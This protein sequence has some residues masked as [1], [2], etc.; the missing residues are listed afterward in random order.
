MDALADHWDDHRGT[1]PTM[2]DA[3][4]VVTMAPKLGALGAAGSGA[5]VAPRPPRPAAAPARAAAGAGASQY[6]APFAALRGGLKLVSVKGQLKLDL[7][8]DAFLDIVKK[9]LEAAEVDEAF[10][11]ETYPD[12]AEAIAAGT[13][14][15]AKHHF[16]ANGYL[17]GRRPFPMA[18]DE[19]FYLAENPDVRDGIEDGIFDS[20]QDHFVRCGYEE[21]RRPAA[22]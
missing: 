4:T 19:A 5:G 8:Y 20:A 11:R 6:L 10:Y 21:G 13:Y 15:D 18:V 2:S 17:E 12:V 7:T 14:R 3:A 9:L 1:R 16:L 22:T